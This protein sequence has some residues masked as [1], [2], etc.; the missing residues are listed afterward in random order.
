MLTRAFD[1]SLADLKGLSNMDANPEYMK[2]VAPATDYF[3]PARGRSVATLDGDP[4][5]DRGPGRA[6]CRLCMG[7]FVLLHRHDDY[8]AEWIVPSRSVRHSR[9]TVVVFGEGRASCDCAAN[10]RG[11]T[12]W[13]HKPRFPPCWH[14]RLAVLMEEGMPEAIDVARAL[15]FLDAA[16]GL[17]SAQARIVQAA[18]LALSL[19][20][21][22]EEG[23]GV[24]DLLVRL[25]DAYRLQLGSL[26]WPPPVK[27]RDRGRVPISVR[28]QGRRREW[29][30]GAGLPPDDVLLEAVEAATGEVDR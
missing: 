21:L 27:E 22:R 6:E 11:V 19:R 16:N 12:V 8:R 10:G 2:M 14:A 4:H 9:Y 15:N 25:Y 29:Q 20:G 18:R 30:V 23:A 3:P 26:P 13:V 28:E 1:M 24:S 7:N 5:R 17:P